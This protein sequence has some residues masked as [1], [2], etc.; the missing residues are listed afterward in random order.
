MNPVTVAFRK[1]AYDIL[2][3]RLSQAKSEFWDEID[4]LVY[5]DE[6]A[7]QNGIMETITCTQIIVGTFLA[8]QKY[9]DDTTDTDVMRVMDALRD[10]GCLLLQDV[11]E[12]DQR[13]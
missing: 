3:E 4:A 5:P 8:S 7:K 9:P 6:M 10:I 1:V 13:D 11:V 2:H 12:E